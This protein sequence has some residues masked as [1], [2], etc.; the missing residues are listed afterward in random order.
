[1]IDVD[2]GTYTA[3]VDSI[4]DG[5]A[6]VFVERDGEDVASETL[7]VSRLP[8][9]GRHADAILS[10]TVR[11]GEIAEWS[12]DPETTDDRKQAAQDRF[13]RLSS[14]PPSDDEAGDDDAAGDDAAVED[15]AA[16]DAT[17][18]D[19]VDGEAAEDDA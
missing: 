9:A 10:V 3:V 6:T 2:D 12:Y 14:R 17:V 11:D 16:D 1:M 19:A 15:A 13:D 5:F 8:E 4:E 7:D 18:D